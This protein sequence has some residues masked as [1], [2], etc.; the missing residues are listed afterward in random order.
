MRLSRKAA[1]EKSW[2]VTDEVDLPEWR[3]ARLGRGQSG[4][5][6]QRCVTFRNVETGRTGDGTMEKPLSC[7]TRLLS[8]GWRCRQR[9]KMTAESKIR[10]NTSPFIFKDTGL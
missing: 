10:L 7:P 4:G 9:G 8:Y 5:Q 1:T 6:V 3:F 2:S